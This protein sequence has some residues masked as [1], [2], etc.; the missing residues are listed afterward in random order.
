MFVAGSVVFYALCV[1]MF[2]HF[3]KNYDVIFVKIRRSR[4]SLFQI[5][6]YSTKTVKSGYSLILCTTLK[7]AVLR[8][9]VHYGALCIVLNVFY[10]SA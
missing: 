7:L 8:L 3:S 4:I 9:L 6:D 1:Y 5:S 10:L 2:E